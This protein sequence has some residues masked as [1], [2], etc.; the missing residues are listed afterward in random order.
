VGTVV[1]RYA[2]SP[3]GEITVF[4]GGGVLRTDGTTSYGLS[5]AYTGRKLDRE[6]GLPHSI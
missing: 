5:V 2:Y 1:E 6:S 3:Y 4:D